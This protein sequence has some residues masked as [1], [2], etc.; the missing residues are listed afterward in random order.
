MCSCD[1]FLRSLKSALRCDRME[2]VITSAELDE[3]AC[4]LLTK[5]GCKC[6]FLLTDRLVFLFS[7]S[8]S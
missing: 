2:N 4:Q 3:I 1:K 8:D 7:I 6:F 5:Q